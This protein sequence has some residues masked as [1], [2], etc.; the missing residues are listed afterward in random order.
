MIWAIYRSEHF[1]SEPGL[2]TGCCISHLVIPGQMQAALCSRVGLSEACIHYT[3]SVV[4]QMARKCS[5]QAALCSRVGLSEACIHCTASVFGQTARKCSDQAAVCSRVGLSQ[6]SIHYTAS[7]VR[8]MAT[9]CSVPLC[10]WS[11]TP[12]A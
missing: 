6:A 1:C 4:R 3:A 9:K 5:D 7:V 8:Q 10:L 12:C 11:A 2:G